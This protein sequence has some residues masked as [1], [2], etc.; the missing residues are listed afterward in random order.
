MKIDQDIELAKRSADRMKR[1]S[2][3]KPDALWLRFM[4]R[5]STILLKRAVAIWWKI[6]FPG[7]Q[8]KGVND[9]E[10]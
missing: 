2:G 4:K 6:R 3:K 1:V 9:E 8:R 10:H 7:K 5:E